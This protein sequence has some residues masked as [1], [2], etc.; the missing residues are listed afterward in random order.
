MKSASPRRQRQQMG[1]AVGLLAGGLCLTL[2]CWPGLAHLHARGPMHSGHA[3]LACHACHQRAPGT[4]RQQI[5]AKVKYL[6]GWR[7]TGVDLGHQPVGN[8]TCLACHNRPTDRHP[9][10]RF[11]EPRFAE[12]RAQLQ[13]QF[14]PSCHQEHTGKRVTQAPTF[15]VACHQDLSLKHDPLTMPHGELIATG[16]WHSCLGCHDFH[17]NH[18][19][20][21]QTVVT[22]ALPL[23]QILAYFEGGAT[24]YSAHKHYT[25]KKGTAHE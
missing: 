2:L 12:V 25:A 18:V 10:F 3:A 19:M 4:M 24:P 11:N 1:Y 14:C 23:S 9:V 17:G 7:R 22:E 20:P 8:A 21:R 5:Q 15:C 13:P 16:Q 6:L